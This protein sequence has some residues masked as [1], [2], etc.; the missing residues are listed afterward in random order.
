MQQAQDDFQNNGNQE[1]NSKRNGLVLLGIGLLLIPINFIFISATETVSF[2]MIT[3]TPMCLVMGIAGVLNPKLIKFRSDGS[4]D[5]LGVILMVASG[6]MGFMF[7][8]FF[9]G[10]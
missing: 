5:M 2:Y 9:T 6:V 3:A 4:V 7:F 1:V 8:Y 10:W